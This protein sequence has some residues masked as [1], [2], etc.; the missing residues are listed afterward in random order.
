MA[1][2]V[3]AAA[4]AAVVLLAF[5]GPR[6]AGRPQPAM[7]GPR[8]S[9]APVGATPPLVGVAIA[10]ALPVLA[11]VLVGPLAGVV[12]AA[13]VLLA[14]LASV[15]RARRA[16]QR[17]VEAATPELV[18]LFVVAAAAGHPVPTCVRL[19]AERA[20]AALRAPLVAAADRAGRDGVVVALVA[21]G[22]AVGP[23]VA[24]LVDALVASHRSGSP[25]AD[26]LASAAE[27][28]RDARRRQAEEAARRLPVTLLFPLVCCVLPAFG[29][30]TVVPLLAA[31]LR[32]LQP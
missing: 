15:R 27:A 10:L 19:V 9:R 17:A 3:L 25:L 1:A 6:A 12:A 11:V 20:P 30:L 7:A 21:F 23:S 22:D 18:D 8:S 28:A 16:R 2:V 32:S 31:S 29:L 14:R 4:S 5:G 13:S 24:P 26:A